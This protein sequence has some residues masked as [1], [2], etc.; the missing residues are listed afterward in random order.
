MPLY[1]CQF[2]EYTTPH[3]SNYLR[4]LKSQKHENEET[5]N[6]TD[7][8]NLSKNENIRPFLTPN[9][10]QNQLISELEDEKLTLFDPNSPHFLEL[11]KN[12]N[13]SKQKICLYCNKS[14]TSVSHARRHMI[15][16]CKVKK[17]Y[18]DMEEKNKMEEIKK[19]NRLEERHQKQINMLLE[20]VGNTTINNNCSTTNHTLHNTHHNTQHNTHIETNN[21]VQL[22]NYG[23][24]DLTMLTENYMRK[25]VIYPYTAIPKMIKKIHFNDNYLANKNIRMLNKKDNK[26]QIRNNDKW[27]FV[28][29]KETLEQLINE[30]NFQLDTYYENNKD[31]FEDKY[32]NRYDIFQDKL[33]TG[34][35]NV[36][37]TV[38]TGSELI[39]WNSM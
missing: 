28:D 26:I 21:T 31:K 18:L 30:K 8:I 25:M 6:R 23:S 7:T 35:R 19:I 16:T 12:E 3:K 17:Y 1:K 4:H 20:K 13:L 29:K 37:K 14:F 33:T 39:F 27:E 11:L 5:T 15:K 24:E 34:E 10:A 32:Q 9:L 22:N 38:N 36:I 2:C